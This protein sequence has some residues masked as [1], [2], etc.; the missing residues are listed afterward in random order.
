MDM[1]QQPARQQVL[2]VDD[3][4]STVKVFERML[5][6]ECDIFVATCGQEAL[7]LLQ[8][9]QPDLILLDVT[10]PDMDGYEV[11][12]RLKENEKTQ[13]IPV[14]FV[15]ARETEEDAAQGLEAGA[16]DYILKS[17]DPTLAKARIRNYLKRS[18]T[19]K[20]NRLLQHH[21][22]TILATA[23]EGIYGLDNQGQFTF[24]NPAASTML[25]W[26]PEELIGQHAHPLIHHSHAD[27][28]PYPP[29]KSPI[30]TAL[31]EKTV[32][33]NDRDRFW[34]KDGTSFPVEYV[35]TSIQAHDASTQ[36]QAQGGVVVFRDIAQQK[37]MEARELR[38][39]ISRIAI[40]ALLETSLEPISLPQQLEVALTI[41]LSVSWLSVE[42]KGSIFLVND[43]ADTLMMLAQVGLPPVLLERCARVPFGF[44]LCGRAAQTRQMV[45]CNQL[46]H[47]HDIL[48]DGIS[49]HGHYCMPI[50]FHERLLGVLNLYLPHNHVRDPEEDAFLSTIA[51]TLAGIIERRKLEEQLER[52]RKDLDHL[53]RHDTLTGLPNR[54]LFHERLHQSLIRARR[55]R[56]MMA[57]LFV[58]LDRFKCVN[59]TFGHEVGDM[60]LTQVA[61]DIQSLLREA[62]TVARMGGDEFTVILSAVAHTE[63][64][65][66]VA[67]KIIARLQ[68]PFRIKGNVCEIGASIG[69]G[70]FPTHASDAETL[71]KK[72]DLAMYHVKDRGRNHFLLYQEGMALDTQK[73][74]EDDSAG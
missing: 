17:S 13:A 16:V 24:V 53:A 46:D 18:R 37:A 52:T 9:L 49:E 20:T 39:Q 3:S 54:M 50:F 5:R 38:S 36:A 34:R 6:T 57:L 14:L 1:P 69:I 58:D 63:D 59:D 22:Q 62:D 21:N 48:F 31:R 35:S 47:Q 29:E 11:C 74:E 66:L 61:S 56:G 25:G 2:I 27:G 64:A 23:G 10:M 65:T 15:T 19:E 30:L 55:E 8:T 43:D 45:F 70:L 32:H 26:T 68:R 51:N 73:T 72:A 41:I 44:C 71:I 7:H 67:E 42:Y 60:L 33:R 4:P 12:K 40:S 28:T